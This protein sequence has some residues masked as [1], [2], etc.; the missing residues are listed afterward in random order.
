MTK[1]EVIFLLKNREKA[2]KF[3]KNNP[4]RFDVYSAISKLR[5][6]FLQILLAFSHNLN[7]NTFAFELEFPFGNHFNPMN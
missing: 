6:R 7:F 4:H 3:E 1:I 2:T 5:G